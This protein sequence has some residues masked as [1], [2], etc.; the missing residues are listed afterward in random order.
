MMQFFNKN[1]AGF[2][3][4]QYS[5]ARAAHK[6]G[7]PIRASSE[8]SAECLALWRP[9]WEAGPAVWHFGA[10][11]FAAGLWGTGV[12]SGGPAAVFGGIPAALGLK[13]LKD[14]AGVWQSRAPLSGRAPAF[15]SY[16]DV[17]ALMR[18]MAEDR[19]GAR[20]VRIK[21]GQNAQKL[22]SA[23]GSRFEKE[24]FSHAA[25]LRLAAA[26]AE[27]ART[28]FHAPAEAPVEDAWFGLGFPWTPVE[29]QRLYELT[30]I[31][32]RAMLLPQALRKW[33]T[34]EA[35]LSDASPGISILHGVGGPAAMGPEGRT[36]APEAGIVR[37]LASLGGG[38]LLV[39]TT[40][41]GKGVVLTNLVAQ[42][43]LR[44]DAVIVIDP[45][46]SKR[47]RRAVIGAC[48]AA[49]R[50]A[51]MEFHP[52]FPKRGVRLNPLGSWTRA[53]EIASRV[54]AVLPDDDGAFAAFAWR[55]VYVMTEGMLFAGRT[56]TLSRFREVLERGIEELLEAALMKDLSRRVPSWE[57]M[58]DAVMDE[59]SRTLRVPM[60][61][62]ASMELAAL[63]A[64]WER[65]AGCRGTR[66]CPGAPEPAVEGLLSVYRH[67]R[68]HYAK[69]TASLL[70]VL[71]MLTAGPL[72]ESLSPEPDFRGM[73]RD[74]KDWLND[75]SIPGG[76][77]PMNP[78]ADGTAGAGEKPHDERPIVT[79]ESVVEMQGV[80]Y[81][82]LDAL[83]DGTTASALGSLLLSDLSGAAG[84][85]YNTE[86]SG[87]EAVRTSIFV[88]ETANVIN[89]P[90]IELL[91]KGMEAGFQCT[92][93]MQTV[94][95]LE[96]KLGSPAAAR[97]ALG[98]LNNLIA[99]RTKDEA[100]QKFVAESFGQIGRAHV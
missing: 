74:P 69:I 95:D 51:P 25:A 77:D 53:T 11:L 85:R 34:D 91:N 84:R 10:A 17:A 63:V 7:G 49:G 8:A 52:A 44:G 19:L 18:A 86:Q 59:E 89:K 46:S 66:W 35:G 61:A 64:V 33:F 71:S 43:I 39:G 83:P 27:G 48:R 78:I 50:P 37:P 80:L 68:E 40:Q 41:A 36:S 88:D 16:A 98:N 62:N 75:A 94:S 6:G 31:D 21:N 14:A 38:T 3:P 60:G 22:T 67:S 42:A 13:R 100:T 45:K 58:R 2:D 9:A 55:A 65:T 73:D 24:G 1:A 23:P 76:W 5:A 4:V 57:A 90:L 79:L 32:W 70:P 56:P 82:G 29:A 99:L 12:L 47:L 92:C 20:A 93:A 97:M 87:R 30:R 28:L 26:Q 81:L 72:G 15:M 54:C 96:A